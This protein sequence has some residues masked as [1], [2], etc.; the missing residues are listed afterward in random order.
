M[1]KAKLA[2]AVA[3]ALLTTLLCLLPRGVPAD[4]QAV[5]AKYI[6]KVY[7]GGKQVASF[8]ASSYAPVEGGGFSLKIRGS[9]VIVSGTFTI[10]PKAY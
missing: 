3:A 2:L 8:G 10:E 5:E 1:S 6:I 4:A 9:T 7:S